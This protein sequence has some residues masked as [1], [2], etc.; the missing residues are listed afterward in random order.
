M[1]GTENIR[2]EAELA[3]WLRVEAVPEASPD[4]SYDP[5]ADPVAIAAAEGQRWREQAAADAR[6]AARQA[7]K[8]LRDW[9]ILRAEN[10]LDLA[11]ARKLDAA[12]CA[13]A[14]DPSLWRL[15]M[16]YGRSPAVAAQVDIWMAKALATHSGV[17][18]DP[19]ARVAAQE[20]LP[21][22]VT[23]QAALL[24]AMTTM[25]GGPASPELL[26]VGPL[27]PAALEAPEELAYWLATMRSSA[28]QPG[29]KGSPSS[30]GG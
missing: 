3:Q 6:A 17:M 11:Q 20:T 7:E 23:A 12:A 13:E 10:L 2:L 30:R 18:A 16:L 9:A 1:G 4:T 15:R 14:D 28:G 27:A 29:R 19:T 21:Q 5:Q 22:R 8:E 24:E 26:F 25:S